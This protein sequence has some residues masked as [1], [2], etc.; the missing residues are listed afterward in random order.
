MGEG[1]GA[2]GGREDKE[3]AG[4]GWEVMRGWGEVAEPPG[5]GKVWVEVGKSEVLEVKPVM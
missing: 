5:E 4:G 2:D 3:R 1:R